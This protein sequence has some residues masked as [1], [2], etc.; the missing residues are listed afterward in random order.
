MKPKLTLLA[1]AAIAIAAITL[2]VAAADEAKKPDD[3]AKSAATPGP[4]KTG[5][6]APAPAKSAPMTKEEKAADKAKKRASGK[7][8]KVYDIPKASPKGAEMSAEEKAADKAKKR[9]GVTKE[10]QEKAAKTQPGG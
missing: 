9:T 4:Y 8:A 2:P 6:E 3:A 5:V 7:D 10:E 1:T